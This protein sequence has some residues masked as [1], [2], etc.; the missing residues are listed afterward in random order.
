MMAVFARGIDQGISVDK[1]DQVINMAVGV[2]TLEMAMLKPEDAF[3]T[4]IPGKR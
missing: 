1:T 3:R 4:Q 2:V